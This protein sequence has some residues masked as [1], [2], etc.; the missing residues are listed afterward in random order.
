ML[1]PSFEFSATVDLSIVRLTFSVSECSL[2]SPS[3]CNK[4]NHFRAVSSSA[5]WRLEA[6]SISVLVFHPLEDNSQI[7]RLF[8]QDV[9]FQ[10]GSRIK[11]D[12]SL[13]EPEWQRQFRR[14]LVSQVRSKIS[15]FVVAGKLFAHSVC[16][17]ERILS[18]GLGSSKVNHFAEL[19]FAQTVE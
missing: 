19:H 4:T 14:Y 10:F 11:I 8:P 15:F 3:Y 12:C 5:S 1:N 6:E 7:Y 9:P 13:D 17:S 16:V 18:V 2:L